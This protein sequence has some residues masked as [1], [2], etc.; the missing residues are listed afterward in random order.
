MK[1]KKFPHTDPNTQV[2]S[3][4]ETTVGN[5]FN[6]VRKETPVNNNSEV[7]N[8][9]PLNQ[10]SEDEYSAINE[11]DMEPEP[12]KMSAGPKRQGEKVTLLVGLLGLIGLIGVVGVVK[13]LQVNK[14]TG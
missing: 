10:L 12:P 8:Y 4:F 11:W 2:H 3:E 1:K 5:S 14:V 13:S 7:D 9:D 6:A